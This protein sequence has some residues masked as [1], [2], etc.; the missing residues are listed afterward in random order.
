MP[1]GEFNS[2]LALPTRP[3]VIWAAHAPAVQLPEQQM[4]SPEQSLSETQPTQVP[5]E[6]T[7]VLPEQSLLEMQPM[8]V[9]LEQS[10]VLPEQTAPA[11]Q[12]QA[13]A[14]QASAPVAEQS[15]VVRHSLQR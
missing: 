4:F 2:S 5:L 11:P 3:K 10:G 1:C 14:E 9:P 13:P 8:Q 12:R 7:G 15:P 6:Q